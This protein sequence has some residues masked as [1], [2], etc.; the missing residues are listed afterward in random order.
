MNNSGR[1]TNIRTGISS[2]A[3]S[4]ASTESNIIDEAECTRCDLIY[5][6]QTKCQLNVCFNNHRSDIK[7][8]PGSCELVCHFAMNLKCIFNNNVKITILQF[9]LD[10]PRQLRKFYEDKWILKLD[11]VHPNGLNVKLNEYGLTYKDVFK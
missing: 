11:T 7:N 10:G 3:C 2:K 1:I 4:G 8:N 9:D 5:I 6:S